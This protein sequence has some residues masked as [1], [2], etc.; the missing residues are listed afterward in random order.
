VTALLDTSVLLWWLG[1]SSRI[2]TAL[3]DALKEAESVI[4]FSQVSLLEI[5]IKVGIGKLQVDFPVEQIPE[6]AD[7]SG[8]AA[9]PLSNAAIFTLPKLPD[10][11]R[12]PFDRLLVCEAIQQGVPLVTP[13]DTL[14]RYPV[15]ILW[16]RQTC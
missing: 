16:G 4:W 1:D 8:L 9:L 12:D 6:L 7:R 2:P 13:D 3:L 5:Q 10:I 11:H 15:R 14:R